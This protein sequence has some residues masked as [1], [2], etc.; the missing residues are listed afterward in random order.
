MS[1]RDYALRLLSAR[2]RSRKE[3]ESRM[4]MKR[5]EPGEIE[6]IL[7]EL[8][9]VGLVD[10]D[11]FA[12]A[13]VGAKIHRIWGRRRILFELEKKGIDGPT[14]MNALREAYDEDQ[15]RTLALAR[16]ERLKNHYAGLAPRESRRKIFS[17]FSRRGHD[18]E[19]ISGL[20]TDRGEESGS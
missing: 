1:A 6:T 19:F 14:A 7:D 5:F 16:L 17:Y 2:D 9:A 12:R 11:Q 8:E 4:G 3:L 15:V 18:A 10:D 20:L 13:F